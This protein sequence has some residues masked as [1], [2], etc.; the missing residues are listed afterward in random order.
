[1][2]MILLVLGSCNK[3]HQAPITFKEAIRTPTSN[4]RVTNY[5]QHSST[6]SEEAQ[7][8]KD[9]QFWFDILTD[10]MFSKYLPEGINGISGVGGMTFIGADSVRFNPVCTQP[11]ASHCTDMTSRLNKTWKIVSF[12]SDDLTFR[13]NSSTSNVLIEMK[14]TKVK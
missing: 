8:L 12:S 14:M 5:V 4:W 6:P 13:T 7:L 9:Y 2:S 10:K 3:S 11:S 1:M